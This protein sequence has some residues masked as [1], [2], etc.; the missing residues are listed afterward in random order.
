LTVTAAATTLASVDR[1]GSFQSMPHV[2]ASDGTKLYYEETGRGRAIVFV[3]E[4]AGDHRSW[5]PQMRAFGRHYR[6]VAFNA[7]GYP[8][9]DVPTDV[10]RYSQARAV[11][12]IRDTL[13]QIGIERAHVVGLSMG[14]F[15]ALHFGLTHPHMAHSLVV[16][17]CGYG[18]EPAKRAQFQEE[19]EASAARLDKSGAAVFARD[20]ALGAAR[21]QFQNKDPRGWAEF[22]HQLSEHSALGAANTLRGVQRQRPS[23]YDL[24]DRLAQLT[25]PV[26][27]VN[28]DEDEPCLEPGL[29]LKRTIPTAA[30]VML[31]RTG[32]TINLEEPEAFN[33][34]VRDFLGQVDRG[35][36]G[37]RDPRS[38]G[39]AILGR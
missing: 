14:G 27:I 30:H 19:A 4:F 12:D 8:P 21:V 18:A 1:P 24:R 35:T 28:G 10:A 37:K 16:A 34:A 36:W 9:S 26:L 7:R 5:E 15:A 33:R 20:Y 22:A 2:E 38:I 32:H 17:G 6:C 11:D 3:H 13:N 39:T 23:L 25:V 31:P 29:M